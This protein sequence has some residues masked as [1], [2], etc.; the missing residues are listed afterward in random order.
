MKKYVL[1]SCGTL[2]ILSILL[3]SSC[4]KKQD[5]SAQIKEAESVQQTQESAPEEEQVQL[6]YEIH[7]K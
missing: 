1:K 4:T 2:G 6:V 3:L 5:E 7:Y